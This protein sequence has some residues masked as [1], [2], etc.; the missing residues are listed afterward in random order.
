MTGKGHHRNVSLFINFLFVF[1][2]YYF[3]CKVG[4]SGKIINLAK[5]LQLIVLFVGGR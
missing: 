3:L 5:R 4:K 1:Y 2:Y